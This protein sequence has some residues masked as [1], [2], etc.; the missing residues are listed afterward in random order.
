MLETVKVTNY[1]VK[2]T[3]YSTGAS[4]NTLELLFSLENNPSVNEDS[5]LIVRLSTGFNSTPNL[6]CKH[7]FTNMIF[8]CNS[9]NGTITIRNVFKPSN[10]TLTSKRML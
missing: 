4:N 6:T 5:N 2:F 7:L 8:S 3:N 9:S 10:V 1:D